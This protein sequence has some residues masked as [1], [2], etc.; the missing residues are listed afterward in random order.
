MPISR[1][2][3]ISCAGMGNRLGLGMT[4]A[5]LDVEG[6]SLLIR[7]LEMLNEERDVRIVIGYQAQKVIDIVR[8]YREDVTFVFNHDYRT[9]GTGDS[10][11]LAAQDANEYVLCLDGDLVIHPEDMVKVLECSHEFVGGGTPVTEDPWLLQT[12]MQDNREFVSAFSHTEG[13]WEWNGI[14]QMK[15]YKMQKGRGHVFRS[16]EPYLPV[17]F[18]NIRT[19]EI[20]TVSDYE[21][22]V[23]WVRNNFR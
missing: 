7:H 16:I 13:T 17:P 5:L 22:A 18:M 15:S 21:H 19:R 3:I 12:Y 14:A 4:K 6:K 10:V 8:P 11:A 2:V 9:T 1:T 20:D 23:A